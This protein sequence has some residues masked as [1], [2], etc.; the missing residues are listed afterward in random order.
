M[1]D[2][3]RVAVLG[4]GH[5][6][7]ALAQHMAL[8]N[9]NVRLWAHESEVVAGINAHHCNP[10]FL[11]EL[12]LSKRIVATGHVREAVS[13]AE[14][15]L[16]VIPAQLI[17]AYIVE[18]RDSLPASIPLVICSKGIERHT[19]ATMDSV[20]LE[21]LPEKLHA[22]V[23]VL[24]GP[25]FAAEVAKGIPTN[26]TLAARD[27]RV[28]KLVQ[29]AV[30][31]RALRVYTT[32]DL[33]GVEL[34]GALKNVIAIAI[35]GCAG[36]GLGLNTQAGLITRGLAE[37]ARLSMAM[38]GRPE[39][40]LGLAG[41]GDLILTCTGD[42]SR[43]RQVGKLLAQGQKRAQIERDMRTVAEGIPTA[44]SAHELAQKH[45]VDLPI[46]EQVYQVLYK[47]KSVPEAMAALQNRSL[48]GEWGA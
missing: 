21:E 17:R 39:T 38:H 44:E 5:W 41:V 1:T 14:L 23:S 28:A 4:A 19:L 15:V 16:I 27:S 10:L 29:S 32:D 47:D 26:L 40:M 45:G 30:A 18:I 7:T 9:H 8:R 37:L 24:S 6:G 20:L 34:G 35:G 3:L 12:S 2:S 25:S 33:V 36:L 42:L 31:T 22:G 43:N 48:K 13:D 11:S 46:I